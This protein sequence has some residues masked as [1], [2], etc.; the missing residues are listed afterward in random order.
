[1]NVHDSIKSKP[2][3]TNDEF[4]EFIHALIN[5]RI[6]TEKNNMTEILDSV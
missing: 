6:P 3:S 1:M 5:D 2:Q 4:G